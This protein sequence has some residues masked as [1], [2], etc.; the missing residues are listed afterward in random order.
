MYGLV[1][2][3][4]EELVCSRFGEDKWLLIKEKAGVETEVFISSQCYSDEITYKLVE[5]ATEVLQLP[6]ET[7]LG[8]FGEHWV[9]RT[10]RASYGSLLSA[11]G[12]TLP[13]FLK[14][15][16]HF[17]TRVA[18]IF[19]ELRP[20]S[21]KLKEV[22]PGHARLLYI[23]H[24]RGLESFVIG[25]LHGLGKLFETPVVVT[26]VSGVAGESSPVEFLIE[27][28]PAPSSS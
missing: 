5:A 26:H 24:R 17:H 27:W 14:N 10:A 15:L 3:A 13:E 12:K 9:L 16:P 1:N 7:V 18:L 11:G 23:S 22:G 20:P 25:L 21:F 19:P 8:A 2:N 28:T 4:V 6:V